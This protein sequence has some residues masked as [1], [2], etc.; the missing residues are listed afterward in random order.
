MIFEVP[1]F[2]EAVTV[3]YG[4]STI[5]EIRRLFEKNLLPFFFFLN[6]YQTTRYLSLRQVVARGCSRSRV[7]L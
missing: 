2:S 4:I 5:L 1:H 7:A 3:F 6:T